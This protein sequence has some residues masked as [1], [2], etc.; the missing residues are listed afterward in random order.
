[1]SKT[2]YKSVG[3]ISVCGGSISSFNSLRRRQNAQKF[4]GQL[5]GSI[6]EWPNTTAKWQVNVGNAQITVQSWRINFLL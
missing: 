4:V 6:S 3:S 2:Q 1:M 5:S